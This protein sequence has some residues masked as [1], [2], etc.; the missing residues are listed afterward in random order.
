[1]IK[2]MEIGPMERFTMEMNM[3]RL[4]VN[5]GACE[6][7]LGT[8]IPLGFTI[9]AGRYLM[10]WLFLLPLALQSTLGMGTAGGISVLAF[11]LLGIE[12]VGIMLEEPF[13]VL[14]LE[15]MCNKIARESR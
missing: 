11:G 4:V 14:P 1:M 13:E 5:V 15:A 6:R 2:Q 3:T 10:I 7:I 12:D 8:P 9:H